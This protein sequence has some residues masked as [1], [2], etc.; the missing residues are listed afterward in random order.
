MRSSERMGEWQASTSIKVVTICVVAFTLLFAG[1]IVSGFSIFGLG[2]NLTVKTVAQHAVSPEAVE[3]DINIPSNDWL[4]VFGFDDASVDAATLVDDIM[5]Q[6]ATGGNYDTGPF[7]IRDEKDLVSLAWLSHFGG[8]YWSDLGSKH[9]VLVNDLQLSGYNWS[10]SIQNFSG[11]FDGNSKV[12]DGL[13]IWDNTST[14]V[15]L[16]TD[17]RGCAFFDT[18]KGEFVFSSARIIDLTLQNVS[19]FASAQNVSCSMLVGGTMANA[20]II[21]CS[22]SGKVVAMNADCLGGI[23]ASVGSLTDSNYLSVDGEQITICNEE[24][25]ISNCS[26]N[27]DLICDGGNV[28]GILGCTDINHDRSVSIEITDCTVTGAIYSK[29]VKNNQTD[30]GFT[31]VTLANNNSGD[32]YYFGGVAGYV[33]SNGDITISNCCSTMDIWADNCVGGIVGMMENYSTLAVDSFVKDCTV[34]GHI[35]GTSGVGGLVGTL[36]HA[37]IINCD[38]YRLEATGI[39]ISSEISSI[40]GECAGYVAKVTNDYTN[41]FGKNGVVVDN[42]INYAKV[43]SLAVQDVKLAGIVATATKNITISYC[44]NYGDLTVAEDKTVSI[45]LAGILSSGAGGVEIENSNNYANITGNGIVAGIIANVNDYFALKKCVNYG[46]IQS[47]ALDN[48]VNS[49]IASGIIAHKDYICDDCNSVISQCIN[50]GTILGDN[51]AFGIV[52]SQYTVCVTE[53]DC[54]DNG[55]AVIN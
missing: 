37:S 47:S 31:K 24:I 36:N 17:M 23:V 41:N 22:V 27:V 53:I 10:I 18:A 46:D 16:F 26:T 15:G 19:I 29:T 48:N 35:N 54:I 1:F 12:I 33:G 43:S 21:H 45:L 49:G 30:T 40:Y 38:N 51:S 9:F 4:S 5:S 55:S 6:Y 34:V 50:E 28:G 8:E 42:L 52:N 32:Y 20:E 2:D 25:K 13:T 39:I 11:V 7:E 3:L 44:T 14:D